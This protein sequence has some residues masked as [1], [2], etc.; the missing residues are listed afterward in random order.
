MNLVDKENFGLKVGDK[1]IYHAFS[2]ADSIDIK[3]YKLDHTQNLV[4]AGSNELYYQSSPT[5]YLYI[6]NYG[7]VV[8]LNY[9]ADESSAF[10][11]NLSKYI[12]NIWTHQW[13]DMLEIQISD[14]DNIRSTFDVITINRFNHEVNK[15]IMLNLGQS[16][17]LDYYNIETQLL[18]RE[19]KT[20]TEQVQKRGKILMNQRNTLKFI[21]KILNTKNR[22]SEN[23][24]ILDVPDLA[25]EDEYIDRLHKT[26]IQHFELNQR[27]RATE[28]T[29][30]IAED[31][32]SVFISYNNHRESSRLEWVII[33]LI[34]IEILDSF[35]S[36]IL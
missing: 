15:I 1:L 36:K 7:A 30:K 22:I 5:Q 12:G 35:I 26:L 28:N 31:N 3:T 6:L 20:Y 21:G 32:L 33:I 27:N 17:T 13:E 29:I 24:Y 9:S 18:L 8:F 2:I 4:S 14:M 34:V 11:K 16:V 19:I 25:W 10:I 23:L